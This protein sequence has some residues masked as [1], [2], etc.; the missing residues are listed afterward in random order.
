MHVMGGIF[1][2]AAGVMLFGFRA[3]GAAVLVLASAA[4]ALLIW[5]RVGLRGVQLRWD[6][7]LWLASL[8]AMTLPP[9]LFRGPDP[10]TG[11]RLWPILVSG[12]ILLVMFT[13]LLGGIGSGRVHPVLVTHLLLF[14]CFKDLL[15]PHYVLDR[16]H[17]IRGELFD[18]VPIEQTV[19]TPWIRSSPETVGQFEAYQ[20]APASQTLLEFTSGAESPER[21]AISLEALLRDRM[22]P[23]EDLIVG[24]HPAPIGLGS[25]IAVIIGG[26]F[27]LYRGLIDY[28][29]PMIIIFVAAAA[30]LLLPVPVVIDEVHSVWRWPA[31]RGQ[32]VDWQVALT[33]V[34]YEL[35]AGPLMFMAFFLATAPALRPVVPLARV[36]YATIAGL[37]T[38]IFQL[39]VSV[40]VG[41]YLALL[42]ASGLTPMFDKAI[43]PRTLV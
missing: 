40:S 27:L 21:G 6:H 12:G 16:H 41:P 37:L 14:V 10:N 38:A 32:D 8:L 30:M 39:Y 7:C 36:I 42:A 13:W 35:V 20:M 2:L 5:R 15:V 23:L 31:M 4:A 33:L 11:L 24:G 9:H 18:A 25:A 29:V 26:L 3:V 34:N 22:P 17:I 1:L 28:R 19:T 43:R